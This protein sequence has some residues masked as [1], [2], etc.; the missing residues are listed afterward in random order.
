MDIKIISFIN[1][2][3]KMSSKKPIKKSNINIIRVYFISNSDDDLTTLKEYLK[4]NSLSFIDKVNKTS[5][6]NKDFA[7]TFINIKLNIEMGEEHFFKFGE[8]INKILNKNYKM[9]YTD[10]NNKF[11]FTPTNILNDISSSLNMFL[12]DE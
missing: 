9:F 2:A 5:T 4:N 10:N 1:I 3:F 7:N 8:K 12:N 6:T 11:V